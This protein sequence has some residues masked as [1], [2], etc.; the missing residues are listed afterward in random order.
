MSDYFQIATEQAKAYR[1]QI[2]KA[3]QPEYVTRV[4]VVPTL[5]CGDRGNRAACGTVYFSRC[6]ADQFEAGRLTITTIDDGREM[7][8]FEPGTW[9]ECTVY[10]PD[11]HVLYGFQGSF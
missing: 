4:E 3:R 7:R 1:D 2:L 9:A 8:V 5:V 10:G 6:H 11:D